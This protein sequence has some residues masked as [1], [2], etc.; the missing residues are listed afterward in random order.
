MELRSFWSFSNGNQ[1]N[2]THQ[3]VT[4]IHT[5]YYYYIPELVG[6]NKTLNTEPNKTD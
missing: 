5:E 3:P 1:S 4:S 6:V 2:D